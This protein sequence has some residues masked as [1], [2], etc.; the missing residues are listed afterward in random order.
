MSRKYVLF[1]QPAGTVH[2]PGGDTAK[3]YVHS[4]LCLIVKDQVESDIL[5]IPNGR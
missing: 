2:Y 3:V 1:W 5:E 4:Q